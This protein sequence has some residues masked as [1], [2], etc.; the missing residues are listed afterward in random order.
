VELTVRV[1]DTLEVRRWVLGFG[2][3]AEVAEP[4][5]L[6]EA[7]R[8]EA[9]ALA[10]ALALPPRKPLAAAVMRRQTARPAA[11]ARERA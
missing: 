3:Q 1:A 6:R 7:L 2:A 4:E 11:G 9:E 5:T 10:H 8:R